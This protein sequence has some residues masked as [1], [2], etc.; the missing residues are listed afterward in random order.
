MSLPTHEHKYRRVDRRPESSDVRC[1]TSSND[2]PFSSSVAVAIDGCGGG[3]IVIGGGVSCS[4]N[5]FQDKQEP[6]RAD[7]ILDL[8]TTSRPGLITG[9]T[10][11]LGLG[12][13]D[14]ILTDSRMAAANVNLA[15]GTVSVRREATSDASKE[16][17]YFT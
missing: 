4:F 3:S 1:E 6:S 7:A 13:H 15:L 11:S 16:I 9:V 12:N 17:I 10:V 5:L 2:L 14:V 8:F